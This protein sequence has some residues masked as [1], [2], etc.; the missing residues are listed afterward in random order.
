MLRI[1]P[2]LRDIAIIDAMPN[3][4]FNQ[5]RSGKVLDVGCGTGRLSYYLLQRCNN[6]D[7]LDNQAHPAWKNEFKHDRYITADL[8]EWLANEYIEYEVVIASDVLEHLKEWQRAFKLLIDV[9]K[10]RVIVTVPWEHSYDNSD[11]APVGHCNY[12]SHDDYNPRSPLFIGQ[13]ERMAYPYS[14]QISCIA[15]KPE[16]EYKQASYLIV[17]DKRQ[18]YSSPT[19]HV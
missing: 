3:W 2:T 9:A 12:F 1:E 16:D 4:D 17:V 6:V 13:F 11:P 18:K 8:F 5:Y 15:S 7:A 10:I 14:T 19:M